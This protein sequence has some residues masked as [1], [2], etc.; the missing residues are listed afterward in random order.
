MKGSWWVKILT[1]HKGNFEYT[2]SGISTKKTAEIKANQIVETWRDQ[3]PSI[4]EF[5]A[6]LCYEEA[7]PVR[8][9]P[10]DCMNC[11]DPGCRGC[12]KKM[13]LKFRREILC[14]GS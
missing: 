8:Q 10:G 5:T 13:T 1:I 3:N 12:S 6:C 11:D 9:R 4:H 2:I 14:V 7:L